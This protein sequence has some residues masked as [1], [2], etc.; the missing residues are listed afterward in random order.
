MGKGFEKQFFKENMEI[1]NEHM[2][3]NANQN[4]KEMMLHI[5]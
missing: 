3:R 2:E 1:A 4:H 5:N